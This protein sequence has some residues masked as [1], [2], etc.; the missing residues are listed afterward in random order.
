MIK[1]LI[2]KRYEDENFEETKELLKNNF[3]I[4][5]TIK[6]IDNN[7]ISF[8]IVAIM[9][10]KVV[11]HIRVDKLRNI[12]KDCYYY[13]LNYVCVDDKYQKLGICTKM[14]KFIFELSKSDNISYIELTSK[15]SRKAANHIYLNEGFV[16]KDTNVF[17]KYI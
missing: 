13:I 5:N 2:I 11:G 17:I 7:E 15:V 6:F 16:I 9:Q 12:G 14:L 1:D 10:E 3:R 4:S 8:S